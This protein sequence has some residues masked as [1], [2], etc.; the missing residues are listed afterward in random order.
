MECFNKN[1]F[2]GF[3]RLVSNR[4]ATGS[5]AT[6]YAGQVT[7]L[8]WE[9]SKVIACPLSSGEEEGWQNSWEFLDCCYYWKCAAAL[10]VIV[11]VAN[12]L[13][14]DSLVSLFPQWRLALARSVTGTHWVLGHID[15]TAGV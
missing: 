1:K 5:K 6:S 9:P 2:L 13:H 7:P 8:I 12:T 4:L 11:P 3:T 10:N 14:G 15:L